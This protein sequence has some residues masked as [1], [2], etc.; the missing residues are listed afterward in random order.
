MELFVLVYAQGSVMSKQIDRSRLKLG[1]AP[2]GCSAEPK[3]DNPNNRGLT[4]L[5][6]KKIRKQD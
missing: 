4:T 6:Y 3:V 5:E 1:A 2:A